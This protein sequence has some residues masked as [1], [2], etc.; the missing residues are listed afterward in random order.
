MSTEFRPPKRLSWQERCVEIH[1]FH[2][3][4]IKLIRYWSVRDTSKAL[5]M[6]VGSVCEYLQLA[7]YLRAHPF[8]HTI[9][10]LVEAVK[11]MRSKKSELRER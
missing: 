2:I 6:A 11:W 1:A 10:G 4:N 9:K 5:N 8:M 3:Y 7:E